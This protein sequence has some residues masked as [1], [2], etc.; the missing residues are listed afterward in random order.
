MFSFLI[1]LLR[2]WAFLGKGQL[3]RGVQKRHK[4]TF[5]GVSQRCELKN[6][7]KKHVWQK[8]GVD[9]FK[10]TKK[11]K[12]SFSRFF[13]HVF[14]R[15]SVRGVQKHDKKIAKKIWMSRPYTKK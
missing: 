11:S 12:P 13:Y 7:L 6:T 4:N 15:F 8:N 2:F 14:G 5:S 9:L 10:S 1:F 3:V